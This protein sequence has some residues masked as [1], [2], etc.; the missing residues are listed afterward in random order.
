MLVLTRFGRRHGVYGRFDLVSALG[1]VAIAV[2]SLVI[3]YA[4][5]R[6]YA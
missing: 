3:A 2:V 5:V 6:G 4:R 1:L